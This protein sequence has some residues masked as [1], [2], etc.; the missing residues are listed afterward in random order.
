MD[1]SGQHFSGYETTA[2]TT[3]ERFMHR[4]IELAESAVGCTFPNPLVGA[5]IV[6]DG[7]IIGEGWHQAAGEAHAEIHALRCAGERA[8]GATLYS[9]L[10]P[11]NHTGRTP[12]C[13]QAII[14]AGIATLVYAV[15]DCNPVASGGARRLEAHGIEV[16]AGILQARAYESIRAFVHHLGTGKPWVILKSAHSL[17]GRV[18]T[19]T[20]DSQWITGAAARA[21][22]HR[23]RQE[24]DAILVGADTMIADDPA[25]TVRLPASEFAADRIRHPRPVVLDSTGRVP[26]TSHLYQPDHPRRALVATTRRMP[27]EYRSKLTALGVS[28]IEFPADRKGRVELAAVLAWLGEAGLQ[29]VLAEG[30]PTLHG[31]LFDAGLVDEVQAFI[32]PLIIGGIRARPAVA[33]LGAASLDDALHLHDTRAELHGTDLLVR[34]YTRALATVNGSTRCMHGSGPVAGNGEFSRPGTRCDASTPDPTF[35]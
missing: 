31:A 13:T 28:V 5:V 7:Q 3:H 29:S 26:L 11:C 21:Q 19:R 25:L 22:G 20:G 35:L 12:P 32:A 16:I 17:D 33:G 1:A 27:A 8:R 34:G 24:V 15:G 2:L 4:A 10:E 18:A 14:D 23:L 9:T 30:G 6:R